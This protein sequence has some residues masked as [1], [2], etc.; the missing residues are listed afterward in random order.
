[1]HISCRSRNDNAN[2]T[3]RKQIILNWAVYAHC[4]SRFRWNFYTGREADGC[5]LQFHH[6]IDL[7]SN[8]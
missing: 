4:V 6:C 1:M 5:A 3:K 2:E 8:S 7:V